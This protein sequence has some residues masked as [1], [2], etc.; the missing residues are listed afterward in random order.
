MKIPT[1]VTWLPAS[2]VG[3]TNITPVA[4]FPYNFGELVTLFSACPSHDRHGDGA[5]PVHF[6]FLRLGR[7]RIAEFSS[8]DRRPG[9]VE[10][11]LVVN[12]RG[13]VY[14]EDYEAAMA[15]LHVASDE[16]Q[17]QGAFNWRRRTVVASDPP[18]A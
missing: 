2:K 6:F 4:W 1:P 3:R 17:R 14:W 16:V 13:V 11:S 18:L 12:D 10:L 15:P 8:W 9:Y 5:E 7:T